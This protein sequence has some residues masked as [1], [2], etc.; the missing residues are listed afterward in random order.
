MKSNDLDEI[1]RSHA[2]STFAYIVFV[3][4]LNFVCLPTCLPACNC[5]MFMSVLFQF[6]SASIPRLG[7]A[8]LLLFIFASFF[9]FQ[10]RS[11]KHTKHLSL[12]QLLSCMC[13]SS[14]Q[15]AQNRHL[16]NTYIG[17]MHAIPLA[18]DIIFVGIWFLLYFILFLFSLYILALFAWVG[19]IESGLVS[20]CMFRLILFWRNG[21][22]AVA[23]W[24]LVWCNRCWCF[25]DVYRAFL[26]KL[27][28]YTVIVLCQQHNRMNAILI[29]RKIKKRRKRRERELRAPQ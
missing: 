11:D 10:Q 12:I 27:S 3:C 6:I 4:H 23:E 13:V 9:A 2:Y 28:H 18:L 16:T 14:Y 24:M 21:N 5:F 22:F 8:V 7:T 15:I 17:L 1:G 26:L 25:L 19:L 20:V 29:V